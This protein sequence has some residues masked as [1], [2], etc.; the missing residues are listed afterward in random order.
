M[1]RILTTGSRWA[2]AAIV[3]ATLLSQALP[4]TAQS[5]VRDWNNQSDPLQK[6]LPNFH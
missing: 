4:A 2:L 5:G 1:T 6:P 3:L